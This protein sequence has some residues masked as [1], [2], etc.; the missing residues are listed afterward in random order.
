MLCKTCG[1]ELIAGKAFCHVCGTRVPQT[2]PRCGAEVASGF[3]FCPDCGQQLDGDAPAPV[4][5]P[6]PTAGALSTMPEGLAEKI[7]SLGGSI[8]GERKQVTVLFCDLAGSTAV[9]GQL[10]PEIYGELIEQ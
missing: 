9:A 2:C 1:T 6:A 8:A 7:R 5:P 4:P 10:D 3:R